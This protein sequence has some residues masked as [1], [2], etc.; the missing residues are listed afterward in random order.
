MDVASLAVTW[1]AMASPLASPQP[2]ASGCEAT[3]RKP[4]E[5]D[6]LDSTSLSA[7]IGFCAC[8]ELLEFLMDL[9][10]FDAFNCLAG[11]EEISWPFGHVS[12]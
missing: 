8:S 9:E 4:K 5:L 11:L 12:F 3:L 1:P 6:R 2:S 7:I 10:P